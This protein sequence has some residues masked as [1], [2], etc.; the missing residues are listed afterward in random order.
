M[1]CSVLG[2]AIPTWVIYV[3]AATFFTVFL[4]LQ[5][6]QRPR[7]EKGWGW[8]RAFNTVT[9]VL[10]HLFVPTGQSSRSR[11][12]NRKGPLLREKKIH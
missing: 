5:L 2:S 7:T 6:L 1:L 11:E 12:D 10:I 3:E 9:H 8:D 4:V